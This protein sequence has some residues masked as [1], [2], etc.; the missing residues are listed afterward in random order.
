[1]VTPLQNY[2]FLYLK[3][4]KRQSFYSLQAKQQL[5]ILCILLTKFN[6]SVIIITVDVLRRNFNL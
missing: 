3:Y 2:R 5:A 4:A 1:M 6:K